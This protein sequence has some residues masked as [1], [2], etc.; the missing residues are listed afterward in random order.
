MSNLP[1]VKQ[2][3]EVAPFFTPD[4]VELIKRQI[5]PNASDDE[6]KIFVHQCART[7]LDPFARQIYTTIK[8]VEKDGKWTKKMTIGTTIDGFR[9]IAERTGKYAGQV[10][11][12]WCGKDGK[13]VDVWTQPG[14]PVAAKVGV[15]RHDFKEVLWAVARYE[16]YVQ[17]NSSGKP[18]ATW[19]KMADHMIAK[20]AE[21]LAL[22]RAFPQ[23]LSGLFT[24]EEMRE[25]IQTG[26]VDT[27]PQ[28]T[29]PQV[30]ETTAVQQ[31]PQ[32]SVTPD[33]E[34]VPGKSL[35]LA[36]YKL[37]IEKAIKERNNKALM[38]NMREAKTVL[39][40]EQYAEL[41]KHSNDITKKEAQHGT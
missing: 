16:A 30:E 26:P 38:A 1:V 25:P 9:L 32:E 34:P 21:A 4:Q 33:A 11:P 2:N 5:A 31:T 14:H 29:P 20:C 10:G 13:W 37:R 23:E 7:G 39:S 35:S 40:K 6:L 15:L 28:T 24:D 3:S 12:Y 17:N 19:S 27:N 18:L 36:D 8:N 22:R 41:A